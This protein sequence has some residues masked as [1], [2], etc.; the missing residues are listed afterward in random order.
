MR[1]TAL[2]LAACLLCGAAPIRSG[3]DDDACTAE[4][5]EQAADSAMALLKY[6]VDGGEWEKMA[7]EQDLDPYYPREKLTVPVPCKYFGKQFCGVQAS[8]C[9][10]SKVTMTLEEVTGLAALVMDELVSDG[11]APDDG[12]CPFKADVNFDAEQIWC[13]FDGTGEVK[14]SVPGGATIQLDVSDLEMKVECHNAVMGTWWETPY[15]LSSVKCALGAGAYARADLKYCAALCNKSL[16]S[17]SFKHME[18]HDFTFHD[19]EDAL[20]CTAS[21][22]SQK[23]TDEVMKAIESAVIAA[24]NQPLQDLLNGLV[25]PILEDGVPTKCDPKAVAALA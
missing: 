21:G 8:T 11:A 25:D 20:A 12:H 13:G 6:A 23:L 4:Q 24:V 22:T 19:Y 3:D 5:V 15:K 17:S 2:V 10:E 18:L 14:V 9:K 7:E 1:R 16:F